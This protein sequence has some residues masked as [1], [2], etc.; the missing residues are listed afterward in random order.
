MMPVLKSI[1]LLLMPKPAQS[2]CAWVLYSY[3]QVNFNGRAL[4]FFH[5]SCRFKMFVVSLQRIG[6]ESL[7]SY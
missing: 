5:I 7:K 1:Y 3:W 2:S 6:L 4:I